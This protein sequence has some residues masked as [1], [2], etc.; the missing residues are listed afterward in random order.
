MKIASCYNPALVADSEFEPFEDPSSPVDTLVSDSD[1]EPLG[2]LATS[3][4]LSRSDTESDPE[5]F[6]EEDPSGDNSSDTTFG[7]HE[8]P[9]AL[10]VAI[11]QWVTA[12]PS[13][14]SLPLP[15]SSPPPSPP[16]SGPS[17]RRSR[18]PSPSSNLS[19]SSS[20]TTLP[21]R[22]RCIV[23]SYTTPSSATPTAPAAPTS[24][25]IAP[26]T[27]AL[28]FIHANL[29]PP[30]KRFIDIK[31]FESM[32]HEI[33]TFRARLI[34]AEREIAT[35]QREEIDIDVREVRVRGR[36]QRIKEILH[37]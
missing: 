26:A 7:I 22:K 25:T 10:Q 18:L 34:E 5:E 33:K 15:L 9:P 2:S 24:A 13:S 21:P 20:A 32:K 35:L 37:L 28:P 23:S 16:H 14:S 12:P 8:P 3:D 1:A 30:R 29:L 31:R 6:S 11:A 19:Y 17:R 36:L 4:Y 27:P